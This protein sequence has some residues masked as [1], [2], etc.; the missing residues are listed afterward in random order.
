MLAFSLYFYTLKETVM[1]KYVWMAAVSVACIASL[2]AYIVYLQYQNYVERQQI[3][4]TKELR[5]AV[6]EELHRRECG[7]GGR[8]AATAE[9]LTI[10]F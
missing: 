1:K 6:G 7:D 10:K 2:Q 3:A 5:I 4:I 8:K 9:A